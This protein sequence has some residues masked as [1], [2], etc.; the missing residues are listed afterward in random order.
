MKDPYEV[1]GVPHGA[2]EDTIKKAY[3]DLARK[4]HPDNYANNPLA[5]LA[6]EKMKEI[7]EAYDILMKGGSSAAGSSAGRSTGTYGGSG[8]F[9]QVR[10]MIQMG[11]LDGAEAK[12]NAISTH[13][14]EW[15]FLRG[16]IAQRRG[17]MDEAAQNFRIAANMDPGNAEYRTAAQNAG[18]GGAYTYRQQQYS[19]DGSDEC[20]NLCSTLLC[21]N[22]LC[23]CC[24]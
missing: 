3:R 17:W 10:S 24:R 14:A 4:Y 20:C 12:L 23:N 2:S 16:V 8:L 19:S 11:D 5:D 1:L 15:Y 7:N 21:L 18:S 22:C 6:Q 9:A 13:N